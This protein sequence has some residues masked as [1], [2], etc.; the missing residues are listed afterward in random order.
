LPEKKFLTPLKIGL[1]VVAFAYFAFTLHAMFTLSW[2][3]EWESLEEP[4]RT[5]IFVEDVVATSCLAFRFAAS[6][7]GLASII[8]YL[9]RKN[10]Q[11]L[12]AFKALRIILVLKEYIG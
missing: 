5:R 4:L 3:G 12:T 6:I 11:K 9:I 8:T 10:L 2:I 1:L 7:I